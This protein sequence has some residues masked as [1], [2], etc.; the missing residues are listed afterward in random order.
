MTEPAPAVPPPRKSAEQDRHLWPLRAD[1]LLTPWEVA[2][3][4]GGGDITADTV[5]RSYRR[6]GLRAV[7]VGKFLRWQETDVTAHAPAGP[8]GRKPS[9]KGGLRR[10]LPHAPA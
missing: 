4:L 7:K 5:I 8:P 10:G 1:R 3:I 6:W 9:P 2:A